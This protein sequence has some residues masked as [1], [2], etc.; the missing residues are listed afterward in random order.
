MS[1]AHSVVAALLL[2][3]VSGTAWA[4]PLRILSWNV[5]SDGNDP[6]VIADQLTQLGRFDI[7]ALQ[8]V[9]SRNIGRYG[10]AVRQGHGS[11]Y[12]YVSS[13]T[14]RSDRLVIIYDSS[15]L[16]LIEVR[17]LFSH[18]G[19]TLNDW[20]HR[21]PLVARFEHP[22]TGAE[23]FFVTVH[24][25]RGNAEL[26][27]EQARALRHWAKDQG[28]AV[29]AAGDFNMDFDF[30]TQAGNDAFSEIQEG[31]VW[32]WVRPEKLV[33]TNWSDND[34]DGQDNYPDSMLDF[35]FVAG[36]AKEW[37]A[38]TAVVVR[39]GDFPDDE[40]TSDHRPIV[41]ELQPAA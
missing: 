33:D 14:G 9:H 15:K 12:R 19:M 13:I 24:L 35:A 38:E 31:A 41:V 7:V 32:K 26:R 5:E 37:S 1:K 28:L 2:V 3:I 39:P 18:A 22:D 20:R 40:R 21:S 23:F 6:A 30:R 10:N 36:A 17:E 11:T 29:I 8:E 16:H 25:A 4:E 34:G 27:T